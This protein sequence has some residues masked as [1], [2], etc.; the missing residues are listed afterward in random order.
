[1]QKKKLRGM[2]TWL[3][4]EPEMLRWTENYLVENMVINSGQ[5]PRTFEALSELIL[6]FSQDDRGAEIISKMK[7]DWRKDKH[8]NDP[9][10]KSITIRL[11]LDSIEKLDRI[12]EKLSLSQRDILEGLIE[13]EST[14]KGSRKQKLARFRAAL[15]GD[16]A[17]II[18]A[19]DHKLLKDEQNKINFSINTMESRLQILEELIASHKTILDTLQSPNDQGPHSL[20]PSNSDIPDSE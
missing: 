19:A 2:K 3:Q 18:S 10:Y 5:A 8:K 12:C 6:D 9:N 16:W 13:I 1:M 17:D 7:S 4:N 11:S 15:A 14:K 20:E